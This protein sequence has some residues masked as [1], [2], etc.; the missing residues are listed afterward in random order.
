MPIHPNTRRCIYHRLN[1]ERCGSP[2]VTNKAR[3]YHHEEIFQRRNRRKI[4][5]LKSPA[6]HQQA[7]M[8]VIAGLMERRLDRRDAHAILRAL[9]L[10]QNNLR[11][12]GWSYYLEK[13]K[14]GSGTAVQDLLNEA[15]VLADLEDAAEVAKQ[16]AAWEE[17]QRMAQL[18]KEQQEAQRKKVAT[19]EN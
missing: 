9:R 4:D 2:A 11:M 10:A 6:E 3:C 18:V 15:D 12:A 1:G 17:S 16:E 13:M 5:M 14:E 8:D 7:I 19:G